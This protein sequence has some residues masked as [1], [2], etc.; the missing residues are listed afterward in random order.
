MSIGASQMAITAPTAAISGSMIAQTAS[1]AP[2]LRRLAAS[3]GL[4]CR[5]AMM[6]RSASLA[7]PSAGDM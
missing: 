6:R 1:A 5:C 3:S 7:R 4:A 2:T